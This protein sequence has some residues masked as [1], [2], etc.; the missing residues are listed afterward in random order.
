MCFKQL[1]RPRLNNFKLCRTVKSSYVGLYRV[2]LV[3]ALP[4]GNLSFRAHITALALGQNVLYFFLYKERSGI[5]NTMNK[6]KC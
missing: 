2:L 6:G 5:L 1:G 3:L 4:I